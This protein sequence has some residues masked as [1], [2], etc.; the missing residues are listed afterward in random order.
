MMP[1]KLL[2]LEYVEISFIPYLMKI[3]HIELPNK[4]WKVAMS[5]IDGKDFLLKF[6]H[7]L[8]DK[9]CPIMIPFNF[10]LIFLILNRNMLYL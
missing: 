7:I 4:R 1:T 9:R 10:A 5:K 8:N 2:V 3:I 6:L